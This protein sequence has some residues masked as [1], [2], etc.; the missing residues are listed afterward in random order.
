MNEID[1]NK[2]VITL[3]NVII[4]LGLPSMLGW[5]VTQAK[6]K[7]HKSDDWITQI[8][9][10]IVYA[11]AIN[12]EIPALWSRWEVYYIQ[13]LPLSKGLYFLTTWDREGHAIFYVALF[14]LTYTF[15]RKHIPQVIRD[16]LA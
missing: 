2:A 16:T 1:V 9:I 15:T 6:R 7:L 14:F 3:I 13:K 8:L 10:V 12:A 5:H 11:L 4:L